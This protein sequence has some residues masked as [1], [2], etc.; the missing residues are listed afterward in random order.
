MGQAVNIRLGQNGRIVI[1]APVRD[2]LRLKEGDT[3][4]LTVE[5]QRGRLVLE[6]E[7]TV[8]ARLHE[9]VGAAE[10]GPLVSEDLLRERREEGQREAR[11]MEKNL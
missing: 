2:A 6:T 4:L 8:I 1:P 3:L 5:P 10:G 9:L 7:E 11:E